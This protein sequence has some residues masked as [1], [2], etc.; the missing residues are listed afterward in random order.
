MELNKIYNMDCLVG[1]KEI[2]DKMI[3]LVVVDPPYGTMNVKKPSVAWQNRTQM[4]WD[5]MIDLQRMFSEYERIVRPGGMIVVFSAEPFT[6]R[7][8]TEHFK[9]IA[10]CYPC[11][12]VKNRP[13]DCLIAKNA[14]VGYFEDVNVFAR[15]NPKH[16]Y[17]CEH[18]LRE[19]GQ[20]VLDFIGVPS[21]DVEKKLGHR[22]AEHFLRTKT[23]QWKLCTRDTYSELIQVYNIDKMDGFLPFEKLKEINERHE[24]KKKYQRIFNRPEN[25]GV[26]SNVFSFAKDKKSFHPTQK[27][28]ALIRHIIELYSN[29][30]DIVLDNC[31]GSGTTAVAAILSHRRFIGFETDKDFFDLAE[32]KN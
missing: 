15:A 22:K 19:Y 4:P 8:R 17:D 9:N 1:M 26:V 28:V 12:Y 30:G 31:M 21:K 18:P 29:P 10:F 25:Q 2:P 20:M 27:P 32:K 23:S 16:D 13:G 24:V 6:S 14:P 11:V 7:L 3:D 5:N